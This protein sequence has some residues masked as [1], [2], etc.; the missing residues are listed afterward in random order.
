MVFAIIVAA[1]KG[2][3]M[4]QTVRKQYLE[5]AGKPLIG[6]TLA[7][8]GACKKID[9]VILVVPQADF[10]VCEQM[11]DR[12]NLPE[13]PVLITGGNERQISVYNGLCAID[14]IAKADDIVVIHDG[15]RPF[16]TL[17][18][19]N[20]CIDGA[21]QTGACITGIPAFDTLKRIDQNECVQETIPRKMIRM[22][23]TPQAFEYHLLKSAHVMALKQGFTGTDDA[24]LVENYG[25]R[26]KMIN[27]SRFNIKITTEEDMILARMFYQ[28][29]KIDST[30]QQE[31]LW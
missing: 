28:N 7:T 5:L 18:L 3:R 27:G 26:V 12:L 17:A 20:A 31:R 23:Q 4:R 15:V 19:L 8:F 1:G 14:T 22:V 16:V 30:T 10:S 29:M 25:A 6:H 24:A 13:K 11:A 21:N 9:K 2:E